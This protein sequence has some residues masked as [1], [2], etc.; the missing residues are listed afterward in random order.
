MPPAEIAGIISGAI[1]VVVFASVVAILCW[2]FPS[3]RSRHFWDKN[4]KRALRKVY[5]KADFTRNYS[6]QFYPIV[7]SRRALS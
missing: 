1:C 5:G 7:F 2:R 4:I 3:C 6:F